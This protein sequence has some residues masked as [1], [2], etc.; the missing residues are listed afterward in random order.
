[1]AS[2]VSEQFGTGFLEISALTAV[3]GSSA[4]ESLTL[5][6]RGAP[7]LAWASISV[8]GLISVIKACISAAVPC[9]LRDSLGVRNQAV[10]LALGMSLDLEAKSSAIESKIRQD[11]RN[12]IG[13]TC[14]RKLVGLIPLKTIVT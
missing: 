12:S 10:D 14:H 5:G 13:I 7:G 4:A 6:N 2:Q 1:M 8:F 11:L 3:I 9:W